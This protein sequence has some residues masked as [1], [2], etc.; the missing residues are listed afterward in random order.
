M[1][2][3]RSDDRGGTGAALFELTPLRHPA[4]WASL[5]VLWVNDNLLKGA[6]IVPGW[7]T[8]KLSDFAFLVVAPVL[9]VA[10]LPVRL[11]GR[12]VIAF[13]LVV[14]VYVAADLSVAVSDAIV[15][16]AAKLGFRWRLW[17]DL[18]DLLALS[19]LPGSWWMSG[20]RQAGLLRGRRLLETAGVFLGAVA[21]LATSDDT[22]Y[23]YPFVVNQ[24]DRDQALT[25]TYLLKKAPCDVDLSA[26]AGSLTADDLADPHTEILGSGQP[27]PLDEAPAAGTAVAGTCRLGWTRYGGDTEDCATVVVSVANGPDVLVSAHRVRWA[28]GGGGTPLSR[29]D[30]QPDPTCEPTMAINKWAGPDALSLRIENGALAFKANESLSMVELSLADVVARAGDGTGCRSQRDQIDALLAGAKSCSVDADC[31]AVQANIDIP[32]ATLCNVYVNRTLSAATLAQ[33]RATWNSECQAR[34]GYS[35]GGGMTQPPVCRAG[36]CEEACPG[37]SVPACHAACTTWN[38]ASPPACAGKEGLLCDTAD[39]QRCVCTGTPATLACE[40][41]KP[42]SATCPLA[43]T[44]Y[45]ATRSPSTVADA[46]TS[47]PADSGRGDLRGEANAAVVDSSAV[48]R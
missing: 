17:P 5:A 34:S 21:C 39:G 14:G 12:R 13:S 26:L 42:I 6:G 27:A 33:L 47:A 48:D 22:T 31:Y 45:Y 37:E 28:S 43:C 20:R 8:G 1:R 25:L 32:G 7:L 3:S 18:T 19:V 23:Y 38:L 9:L 46:G 24:T 15:G 44:D 35:C 30:P 4:W 29:N 10:L 2:P 36:K 40:P 16:L 11:A 41:Q